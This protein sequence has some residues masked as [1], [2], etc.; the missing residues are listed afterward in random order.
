ML[1]RSAEGKAEQRQVSVG[2][3]AGRDWVVR[4][5]L[6]PGDRVIVDNLIRLRPGVAVQPKP[7]AG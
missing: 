7:A 6:K 4:E 1:F 5:G 2:E 3:W